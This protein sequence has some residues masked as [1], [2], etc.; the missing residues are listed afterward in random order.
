MHTAELYYPLSVILKDTTMKILIGTDLETLVTYS[1]LCFW[2]ATTGTES[3]MEEKKK[4][5]KAV[6]REVQRIFKKKVLN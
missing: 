2:V 6:K 3:P 4:K 1:S 5:L